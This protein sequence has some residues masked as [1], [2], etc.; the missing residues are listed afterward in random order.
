MLNIKDF[1]LYISE[2]IEDEETKNYIVFNINYLTEKINKLIHFIEKI[3]FIINS[4]NL[5]ADKINHIQKITGADYMSSL[6]LIKIAT[7]ID[8]IF[9]KQIGGAD[10]EKK[11]ESN[12]EDKSDEEEKSESND[13]DKSDSDENE[14]EEPQS[15]LQKVYSKLTFIPRD[16]TKFNIMKWPS[17]TS[18]DYGVHD[19]EESSDTDTK[20][21]I[22][23]LDNSDVE[24]L[25]YG[26]ILLILLST[27]P[28]IGEISNF[29]LICKS[30]QEDRYFL[31]SIVTL[32]SILSFFTPSF[33]SPLAR[34][35]AALKLFYVL[36]NYSYL[37][38]RKNENIVYPDEIRDIIE[39]NMD[40]QNETQLSIDK[41]KKHLNL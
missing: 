27:L 34:P 26:Y 19:K 14:E 6:F 3:M 20:K 35:D 8:N 9:R 10:K 38:Y 11:N 39:N 24:P 15:F 18:L 31:A 37:Q 4:D 40:P 28:I 2:N 21:N 1:L 22:L 32:S 25:N 29:V 36:D 16:T 33:I 23:K 17:Y 30:L 13:E 5:I 12:D 7:K 41:I